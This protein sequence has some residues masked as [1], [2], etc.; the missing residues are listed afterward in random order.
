METP[1]G[2]RSLSIAIAGG[3]IAGATLINVLQ[4]YTYLDVQI[5]E[6]APKFSERGA[7]VGLS[8][9]SQ[10]ALSEMSPALIELLNDAGAVRMNSTRLVIVS[11]DTLFFCLGRVLS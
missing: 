4:K 5:Y 2:T 7:A 3:G 11:Q 1:N 10:N 9:N 6:S 8:S